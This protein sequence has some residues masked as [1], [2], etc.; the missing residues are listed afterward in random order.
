MAYQ[1]NSTLVSGSTLTSPPF[2]VGDFRLLSVS[3]VTANSATTNIMIQGSNADGLQ[4]GDL[5]GRAS[6]TGWSTITIVQPGSLNQ[7]QNVGLG[8]FTF[9]PPGYRWIRSFITTGV[10]GTTITFTGVSF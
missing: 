2:Y 3:I 5:G 4:S 8:L 10:S 9:D 7:N 1:Y 6:F